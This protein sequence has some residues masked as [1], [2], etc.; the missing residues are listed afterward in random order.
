MIKHIFFFTLLIAATLAFIFILKPFFEPILWAITFAIIFAP[1]HKFILKKLKNRNNL[2]ALLTLLLILITVVVPATT[3]SF[4]VVNEG[5]DLYS[6]IRDGV[7]DFSKPIAWVQSSLPVLSDLLGKVGIDFEKLKEGFSD[8]ALN[9][10]QWVA[11]NLLNIGQNAVTFTILFFLML[12][13][14]FLRAWNLSP[15]W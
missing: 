5:A 2:S 1:L 10:S 13:L 11:T 8:T 7:Y 4:A 3:L 15:A 14:L 6:D 9:T 12:Y